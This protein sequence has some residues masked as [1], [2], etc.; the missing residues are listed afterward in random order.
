MNIEIHQNIFFRTHRVAMPALSLWFIHGFGDSGLAWA[1][2][3]ATGLAQKYNLFVPDMP[4]FGVSPF[5][6][7][8][9]TIEAQAHKLVQ[10]IEKVS[11]A[12]PIAIV[13]HS[14]GGLIA[15]R[16][17]RQLGSRVA[18]Y[19]SVEGNL[20]EADS[21]FSGKVLQ[22]QNPRVFHQAFKQEIFAKADAS[23]AYR[24]YYNSLSFAQPEA[25]VG[26]GTSS[27]PHVKN[28]ACGKDFKALTCPKVYLW[29][30]Q[31]TPPETQ[32]FIHQQNIPNK[33]FEDAGHWHM[34]ENPERFY[35]FVEN[36]L[37]NFR[38]E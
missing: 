20:T 18:G 37:M 5:A 17:C 8:C 34:I 29:G 26:W 10:I 25:L 4:G 23:D 1:E 2:A 27:V 28:N 13:A 38:K 24:R 7:N 33:Q 3:F 9:T 30:S 21:Y 32:A 35:N 19:V 22:Y 16:L 6:P 31:D 11:S 15:T 36:I 12:T 14:I